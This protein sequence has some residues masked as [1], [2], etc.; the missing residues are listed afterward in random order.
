MQRLLD[1]L[2]E[3]ARDETKNILPLTIQLVENGA[4]MGDIVEKLKGLWGIYRE[5]PAF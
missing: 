1:A 5:T 3:T 4:R 2:V